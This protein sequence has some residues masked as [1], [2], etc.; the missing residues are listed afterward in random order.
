M[1]NEINKEYEIYHKLMRGCDEIKRLCTDENGKPTIIEI[2]DTEVAMAYMN[3]GVMPM[4]SIIDTEKKKSIYLFYE[5][6]IRIHHLISCT[7]FEN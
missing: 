1:N 5:E 4:R 2:D 6:Q 3:L 7:N